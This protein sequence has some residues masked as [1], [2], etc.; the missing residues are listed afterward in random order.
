M[1]L[2]GAVLGVDEHNMGTKAFRQHFIE[3]SNDDGIPYMPL[4][5]MEL[6]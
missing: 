1:A 3:R 4:E 6:R 5:W 2:A